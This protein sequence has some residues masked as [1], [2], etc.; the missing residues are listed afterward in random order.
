MQEGSPL[1]RDGSPP[2]FILWGLPTPRAPPAQPILSVSARDACGHTG[3]LASAA[4]LPEQSPENKG[5]PGD[6]PHLEPPAPWAPS[7]GATPE[8]SP[9]E[10]V[11]FCSTML[12]EIC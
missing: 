10:G 6:L 7:P 8:S 2:F 9:S 3:A 12:L 4:R 1:L 5:S 11:N